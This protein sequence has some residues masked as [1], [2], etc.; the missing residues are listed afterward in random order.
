VTRLDIAVDLVGIRI[1]DLA[2]R[3]AGEGKSHWYYSPEGEAETGYF[4]LKMANAPW[5]AYN[6]RRQLKE[7]GTGET[8]LY[9]GL[10]HTRIEYRAIPKK[11]VPALCG[12][13]NPFVNISLAVPAAPKGV[14]PHVWQFFL[15]A[16]QR[17]GHDAA[18]AMLPE[19]K[20][21]QTFVGTLDAAHAAFW[22]PDLIWKSWG[23]TLA[24]NLDGHA[25]IPLAE[26]LG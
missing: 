25:G 6:K 23:E 16:C 24:S 4:G 2:I 1:D 20:T 10:P 22:K 8:Q 18:I 9:G 14:Q 17:R 21:K 15:D 5:K 12:Y 19:G 26:W 3:F 13:K 7:T 11:P